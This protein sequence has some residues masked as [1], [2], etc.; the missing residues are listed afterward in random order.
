MT[1]LFA[2][3]HVE[4]NFRPIIDSFGKFQRFVLC[5]VGGKHAVLDG[6]AAANREI[7]MDLDHSGM[8]CPGFRRIDL[9]FV[10]VLGGSPRGKQESSEENKNRAGRGQ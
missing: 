9:N 7:G 2:G 6:F 8:R 10:V 3:E 5:M 1:V 4:A